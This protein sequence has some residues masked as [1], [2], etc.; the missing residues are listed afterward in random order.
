MKT[1]DLP[2]L[3]TNET[4]IVKATF[5]VCSD[6]PNCVVV[7]IRYGYPSYQSLSVNVWKNGDAMWNRFKARFDHSLTCVF[8]VWLCDNQLYYFSKNGAIVAFDTDLSFRRGNVPNKKI[9]L[10][11]LMTECSNDLFAVSLESS[12][13]FSVF[14]FEP[15][16]MEWIAFDAKNLVCFDNLYNYK[17]GFMVKDNWYKDRLLTYALGKHCEIKMKGGSVVV[18]GREHKSLKDVTTWVNVY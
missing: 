14:R 13:E 11:H 3:E 8:N 4:R 2:M 17:I 9:H 16:T 15:V 12:D 1:V 7:V 10:S 6:Y 5:S 18:S